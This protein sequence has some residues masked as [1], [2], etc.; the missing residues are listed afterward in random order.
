MNIAGL[1]GSAE[2]ASLIIA[3]R[4]AAQKGKPLR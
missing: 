2:S 4:I 1:A 3:M